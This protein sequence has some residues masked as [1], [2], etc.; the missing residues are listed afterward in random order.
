MS[1][2]LIRSS[3]CSL[4]LLALSPVLPL[5]PQALAQ[6]AGASNIEE[7][8]TIIGTR[9]QDGRSAI[10]SAVPVDLVSGD[11]FLSQGSTNLDSQLSILI[12]SYHVDQQAIND[13]SMLVRPARLRGLPPDSSLVL[14]NGK[15]RH[16]AGVIAF[17]GNGVADGS[18]GPDLLPIPAIA[19]KRVQVLRDGAAAQY[20]SDAIAG[21]MNFELKDA[22][23][24]GSAEARW[25]QFYDG[26]GD[27]FNFAGN[28]GLPLTE[29]GFA[30]F[31]FEYRE[32]N[33]TSRAE[34]RDDAQALA[35]AGN[36]YIDDPSYE[37][38]LH[39]TVMIWGA[40]NIM[41]D[42]KFFGNLG[43][44][45]GNGREAYA[46]GNYSQRK[47]EG[48]F[49]FRN[50]HTRGGVFDGGK[51]GTGDDAVQLVKVADLSDDGMSG[52]C[53]K[54]RVIDNVASP[55]DIAAVAANPDC[56]SF[57]QRFPGGFTPRFGGVITDYSA[58]LGLRGEAGDGWTYDLSAVFGSNSVD[59]F[60]RHT[61]NPQLLAEIPKDQLDENLPIPTDYNPGTYTETDYT[62]N[63]DI[64]RPLDTAV[65]YSPL[66][67][68][69]GA[70]YRRENFKVDPGGQ[71]SWY[72]DDSPGGLSE[73]GFGIASNGFP[74]FSP[75]VAG[76]WKRESYAA[77]IDLEAEV[78]Q[79][80]TL[81]AAGRFEEHRNSKN[82][83]DGK[84]TALWRMNDNIALRGAVGT[85]FRVPTAGQANILNV[86]TTL[87]TEGNL[88]DKA[89]LPP[90]HPASA[91]VGGKP[92][93][94][95]KSTNY[96]A[97]VVLSAGD[98]DVTV[99][100]FRIK[101]KDRIARSSDTPLTQMQRDILLEQGVADAGSLTSIQFFTNDFDTTTQGLDIVASYPLELMGGNTTLSAVGNWID[102][103]VD[104]RNPAY[105]D[106]KRVEQLEQSTP[107][108]RFT[109]TAEHLQ[110]PWR[111]MLRGR[112]YDDFVEYTADV[113][114]FRLEAGARWLMDA[115][116]GYS[117]DNGLSLVAGA[118]NL[119]DVTPTKQT[120]NAGC[121]GSCTN[122]L[123]QIYA[124]AAP[125][126]FSGGF[127]YLR[128]LW[129]F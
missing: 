121:T 49:F 109:T 31:S 3:A 39:P 7:V 15:R 120:K 17:L 101:V 4:L 57:I 73:Q 119:T 106:N 115:E 104:K 35:D 60:M 34:Q 55:A 84:F 89:T 86:S 90:T 85:G 110:G 11:D 14:V 111:F 46:F 69:F 22:A 117:F 80:L 40:P 92:L 2:N 105:I 56:F 126:G 42:Y 25:G 52:N 63:L 51:E 127:Y 43:L 112:F 62:F 8:I 125:Y 54:I 70:E 53:P 20:G 64:T 33:P 98:L 28:I 38:L 37:P 16:R 83:V 94:P 99:D 129:E 67:L 19:L 123:G 18:Q 23:E 48:G 102:T 21:V 6:G 82:T 50:P 122:V 103:K 78:V 72:I 118:E 65:F 27:G 41:Y 124:E 32:A 29:S 88:V 12:P 66:N 26:D 30:N 5:A 10:E 61:I 71:N 68:A 76:E 114:A 13:A 107:N 74:G 91:L 59:F 79:N 9:R 81:A 93:K 24:G 77:Y 36:P 58:A 116:L 1:S 113:A 95:E 47:V 44:D 75:R 45:L 100:Y 128:A 108:I 97:G 87:D 96:T